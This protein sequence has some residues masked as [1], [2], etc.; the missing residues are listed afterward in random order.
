[1]QEFFKEM[2]TSF[3]QLFVDV[4]PPS[5]TEA[6]LAGYDGREAERQRGIMNTLELTDALANR[7]TFVADSYPEVMTCLSLVCATN[8][9]IQRRKLAK[10]ERKFDKVQE[11]NQKLREDHDTLS[12]KVEGFIQLE[13]KRQKKEKKARKAELTK[14]DEF[15]K[16]NLE[17]LKEL[18]E[19][20]ADRLK[21]V[22]NGA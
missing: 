1:M 4:S 10:V 13:K 3:K 18:K 5:I 8:L 7:L 11:E 19:M 21:D 9:L 2:R 20:M 14:L 22:E 17:A 12:N 15:T 6:T 16:A